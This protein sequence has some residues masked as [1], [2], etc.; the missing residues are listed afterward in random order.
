[1]ACTHATKQVIWLCTLLTELGFPQTLPTSLYCDNMGPIAL[2]KTVHFMDSQST[3]IFNII[4]FVRNLNQMKLYLTTVLLNKML[5][6]FQP[7]P[8]LSLVTRSS[9]MNLVNSTVFAV[10]QGF[11]GIW[12]SVANKGVERGVV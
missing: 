3:L 7:N 9:H 2:G 6:T 10:L 1:M 8:Y 11:A 12:F 4:L 5:Q